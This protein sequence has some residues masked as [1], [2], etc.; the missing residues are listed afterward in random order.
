MAQEIANPTPRTASSADSLKQLPKKVLSLIEDN[1]PTMFPADGAPSYRSGWS[2]PETIPTG[3]ADQLPGFLR[4]AEAMLVPASVEMISTELAQLAIHFWQPE[5]PQTHYKRLAADYLED[6]ADMPPDILV[7]GIRRWRQT[8]EWWPKISQLLAIMNPMLEQRRR[9]AARLRQLVAVQKA[10][11]EAGDKPAKT[12]RSY[13]D[14]TP[15]ERAAHD[16]RMAETLATLG[17]G[18]PKPL[19]EAIKRVTDVPPL[20]ADDASPI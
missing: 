17:A 5:R 10:K 8:G 14:L 7:E 12:G 15:E 18:G 20:P 13:E 1:G 4:T 9:E 19:A 3:L 6:L 2:V 11:A 16:A